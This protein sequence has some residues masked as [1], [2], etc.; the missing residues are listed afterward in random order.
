MTIWNFQQHHHNF[1]IAI[2]YFPCQTIFT[3]PDDTEYK[4]FIGVT[5]I[6]PISQPFHGLVSYFHH[7]LEIY[8]LLLRCSLY[9]LMFDC[10]ISLSIHRGYWATHR[11][12]DALF[13]LLE[14]GKT[15]DRK[16]KSAQLISLNRN[17]TCQGITVMF[18]P[19]CVTRQK[20]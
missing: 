20:R 11:S 19:A 1:V 18:S 15:E 2:A 14:S 6:S 7:Q 10:H 5:Y 8:A 3:L 17:N 9:R 4:C 12:V 16:R 13:K